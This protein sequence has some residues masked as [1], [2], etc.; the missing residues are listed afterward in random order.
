MTEELTQ[1]LALL[2]EPVGGDPWLVD[3]LW[4]L[5]KEALQPFL[6][7]A[8]PASDG[9]A[10]RRFRECWAC[11]PWQRATF[12]CI[13]PGAPSPFF[14]SFP[15]SAHAPH[16]SLVYMTQNMSLG[17]YQWGLLLPVLYFTYGITTPATSFLIDNLRCKNIS[18]RHQAGTEGVPWASGGL[19]E[20]GA[21]LLAPDRGALDLLHALP[22]E[23]IL[24]RLAPAAAS[25]ARPLPADGQQWATQLTLLVLQALVLLPAEHLPGWLLCLTAPAPRDGGPAEDAAAGL[26]LPHVIAAADAQALQDVLC[27]CVEGLPFLLQPLVDAPSLMQVCGI[28][29]LFWTG[30]KYP[31]QVADCFRL[32]PS[33]L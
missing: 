10:T 19:A 18:Q 4:A 3:W 33:L 5:Y 26:R 20:L 22:W 17:S 28:A 21:Y 8:G 30:N 13:S 29:L 16:T 2:L 7:L 12:H 9:A 27:N 11:L 14:P 32:L 25:G 6:V 1:L 15:S 24:Q 31:S 23:P